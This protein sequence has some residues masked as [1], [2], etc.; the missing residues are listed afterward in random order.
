VEDD[1]DGHGLR[2]CRA[3][4]RRGGTADGEEVKTTSLDRGQVGNERRHPVELAARPTNSIS[5]FRPTVS[6]KPGAAAPIL[7][8]PGASLSRECSHSRK[9]TATGWNRESISADFV[10][11]AAIAT[12]FAPNERVHFNKMHR[13]STRYLS[14]IALTCPSAGRYRGTRRKKWRSVSDRQ[15]FVFLEANEPPQSLVDP[16]VNHGFEPDYGCEIL[17]APHAGCLRADR[18]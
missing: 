4:S 17:P 3:H 7:L 9:A 2:L 8:W 12:P 5:T 13:Y 15:P 10:A 11:S 6:A 14:L 1:R 16:G 18:R